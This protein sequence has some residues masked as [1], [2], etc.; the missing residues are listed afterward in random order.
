MPYGWCKQLSTRE[1]KYNMDR[2]CTKEESKSIHVPHDGRHLFCLSQWLSSL[3][4]RSV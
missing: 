4:L 3:T 2:T 1:F